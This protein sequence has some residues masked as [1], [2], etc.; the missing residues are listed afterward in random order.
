MTLRERIERRG[1]LIRTHLVVFVLG[2]LVGACLLF[3]E[4]AGGTTEI[5]KISIGYVIVIAICIVLAAR[6]TCPRCGNT[7]AE[8]VVAAANPYS[9]EVMPDSCRRCG[10]SLDVEVDKR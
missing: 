7:L 1:M 2:A 8:Y 5:V 9:A 6:V 3:P 4:L 10:L